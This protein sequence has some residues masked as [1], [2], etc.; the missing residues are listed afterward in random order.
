MR[1][2]PLAT[3]QA[4]VCSPATDPGR[5]PSDDG[6][7]FPQDPVAA[8]REK[9]MRKKRPPER[10]RP[11][12][13]KDT[14]LFRERWVGRWCAPR[15]D[16]LLGAKT[17]LRLLAQAVG[18][19]LSRGDFRASAEGANSPPRKVYSKRAAWASMPAV[20]ASWSAGTRPWGPAPR[21]RPVHVEPA[22]LIASAGCY[23]ADQCARHVRGKIRAFP[24]PVKAD[25]FPGQNLAW[26]AAQ[27][28]DRQAPSE[29]RGQ[30][31]GLQADGFALRALGGCP[32]IARRRYPMPDHRLPATHDCSPGI[33]MLRIPDR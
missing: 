19:R 12:G 3:G 14:I 18:R 7:V 22:W 21:C 10:P 33:A 24:K 26:H 32:P 13:A 31:L 16:A 15:P 25:F 23:Q 8:A 27:L 4:A 6:Q 11:R 17:P 1:L 28:L 9:G 5:P 29:P 30:N 20:R 2:H